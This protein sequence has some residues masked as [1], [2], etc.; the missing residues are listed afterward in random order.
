MAAWGLC[1]AG[2]FG[3]RSLSHCHNDT[4]A[5]ARTKDLSGSF[6][7]QSVCSV[8]RLCFQKS[9]VFVISERRCIL[10]YPNTGLKVVL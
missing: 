7:A 5:A 6:K 10:F 4:V 9:Q 8:A 2:D 3:R 1:S